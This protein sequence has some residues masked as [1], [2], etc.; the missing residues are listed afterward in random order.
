LRK[1]PFRM[2]SVWKSQSDHPKS[3]SLAANSTR[4]FFGNMN[5]TVNPACHSG[6]AAGLPAGYPASSL[7]RRRQAVQY[8]HQ[9]ADH[10]E[11]NQR[12]LC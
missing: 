12:F 7:D 11:M 10:Q 6:A 3:I 4:H 8:E 5:C 2:L 1:S 9:Q